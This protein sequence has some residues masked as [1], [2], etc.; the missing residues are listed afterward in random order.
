MPRTTPDT[1]RKW[2]REAN[3]ALRKAEPK[4]EKGIIAPDRFYTLAAPFVATKR[5]VSQ[6]R[7]EEAQK[8]ISKKIHEFRAIE[9]NGEYL[10][11]FYSS[12]IDAHVHFGF[13]D[14]KQGDKILEYIVFNEDVFLYDDEPDA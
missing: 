2:L 1:N 13:I 8:L 14:E 4:L 11:D 3:L 9:D 7:L 10:F 6:V 12:Y 5:G